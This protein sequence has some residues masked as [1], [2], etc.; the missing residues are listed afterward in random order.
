ME[1]KAFLKSSLKTMVGVAC[2]NNVSGKKKVFRNVS[3]M[4]EPSF[5]VVDDVRDEGFKSI[6][7]DL[8]TTLGVPF[9]SEIGRPEGVQS[10]GLGRFWQENHV[11]LVKACKIDFVL[12]EVVAKGE[13]DVFY[14]MLEAAEECGS[15]SIRS[16]ASIVFHGQKSDLD[17]L[18]NEGEVKGFRLR[19]LIRVQALEVEIPNGLRRGADKFLEEIV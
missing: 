4:Q 16:R 13:N 19:C 17:L 7:D 14:G 12:V 2:S 18:F 15:K 6:R 1:S 3:T 5:I 10:S 8:A 9:C 11:G